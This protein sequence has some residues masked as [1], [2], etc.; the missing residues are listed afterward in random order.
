MPN[1]SP[2][3]P[4]DVLRELGIEPDFADDTVAPPPDK[5]R[6]RRLRDGQLDPNSRVE[7]VDCVAA[8]RPWYQAFLEVLSEPNKS[9]QHGA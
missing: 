7:V 2:R 6:L 9:D 3:G 4:E 8:F 1:E 5:N